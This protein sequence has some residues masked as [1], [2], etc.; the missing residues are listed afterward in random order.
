MMRTPDLAA[1]HAAELRV[2]QCRRNTRESL[3]RVRAASRA[4]LARPATLALVAGAAVL[5]GFWLVRRPQ[6]RATSSSDGVAAATTTSAV[7]LVLAFIVRYGMQRLPL[8]LQQV[9]AAR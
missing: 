2:D 3:R 1:I 4:A 7:G 8:I 9:W 6:P 5:F